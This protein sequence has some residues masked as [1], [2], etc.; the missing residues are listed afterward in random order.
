[1]TVICLVKIGVKEVIQSED[2]KNVVEDQKHVFKDF[3]R[4][5]WYVEKWNIKNK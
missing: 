4:P 5:A 3:Q 1:M 2:F